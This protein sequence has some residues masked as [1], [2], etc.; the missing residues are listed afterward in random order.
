MSHREKRGA[1]YRARFTDPTGAKHSRTFTRKV[2]A[3]RFLRELDAAM[4]RGSWVDPRD[5]DMAVADWAEEFLSLC[6]RL[7]ERTQETYRRD[8]TRFVLPRFGTYRLGHIPADEIENWLND[9]IDAGIAPSS[10]LRHYRTL[11]RLLQDAVEKQ[12]IAANPCDRVDPPR[13]PKREMVFLDWDEVLALSDKLVERHRT[14]ILFAVDTG[15]RWSEIIGLRRQKLDLVNRKVRVTEQLVRLEDGKFI[16]R[17]PKTAAGVRSISISP[18]TAA[19]VA[20]HIDKF[21]E[22]GKD[23]M[24]FTSG[25]GAP[26][27][28]SSFLTHHFGPAR[29][30]AGL[31]CRFHDLRHTSVALAIAA[32]AHPKAIQA[33]MGHS[34]INV[35][36]DR[37]G[38]LFPELDVEIADAFHREFLAANISRSRIGCDDVSDGEVGR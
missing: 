2:D 1:R 11:R 29:K 17:E 13:V 16:R 19:L 25:S 12:K 4:L 22:A 14:M 34:S 20:E 37:Y 32:G 10:V 31:A 26:I 35:T 15:M 8:L 21:T 33:R 27:S 38:H 7:A 28:S 9:E 3:Q 30:A 36:L 6:R 18:H 24:V 23:A 5:A